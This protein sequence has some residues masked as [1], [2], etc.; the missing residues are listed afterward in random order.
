MEELSGYSLDLPALYYGMLRIRRIE[1]AIAKRYVEQEMRCPVHLCIGEEAVAV[2]V[3]H[4]LTP[5]DVV[6]GNHRSHGHFLAKGGCLNRMMAEIYGKAS[7]CCGGRGGSMHLIDQEAGFLG[8][9][10]IVGGTV[11]LAVGAAWAAQLRRENRVAVVFFGDGCFEEGVLHESMNFAALKKLPVLFVCENNRLSVYTR[12]EERQPDRPI[13]AIAAAHGLG[14]WCG[15]GNDVETVARQAGSAVALAR[16]G[17]GPQFLEF[18]TDRWLGHVGPD[19]DDDLGYRP[20]EC[21]AD[22]LQRCPLKRAG[23][24]LERQ[25]GWKAEKFAALEALIQ[26]EVAQA[27]RFVRESPNPNP[28]TRGDFSYAE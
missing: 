5:Q 28:Q 21:Q 8:A 12:I 10:P 20:N 17:E 6:F 2:G 26:E 4:A 1:E 22:R 19:F 3:C 27:W 18:M 11:P 13:H 7:G 14:V 23:A 15:D 24:T 16:Q 9:V 25:F